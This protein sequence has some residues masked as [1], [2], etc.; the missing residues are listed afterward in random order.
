MRARAHARQLLLARRLVLM[1]AAVARAVMQARRRRGRERAACWR[2]VRR[3]RRCACSGQVPEARDCYDSLHLCVG[4][5]GA[6]GEW[7]DERYETETEDRGPSRRT[8]QRAG[9]P[10]LQAWREA[11]LLATEAVQPWDPLE[12]L[13]WEYE[14][15]V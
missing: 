15:A 2:C 9:S 14:N 12:G 7:R 4:P 5:R 13:D 11:Q 8:P 10:P 1:M 3:V 6:S